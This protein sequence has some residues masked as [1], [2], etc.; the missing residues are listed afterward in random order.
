MF[1]CKK[2]VKSQVI[3]GQ[4]EKFVRLDSMDSRY[5]QASEAGLN[6]CT[7]N[8]RGATRSVHA[9]NASSGSFKKGFRKGSKGIA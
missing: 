1:D 3:S 9:N 5:S 6:K 2:I 7:L 4:L 8:L